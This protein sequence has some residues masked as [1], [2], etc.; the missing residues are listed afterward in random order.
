[1]D[2]GCGHGN[3]LVSCFL[4]GSSFGLG[5]DYGKDSIKYANEIKKKK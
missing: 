1:M 3:F 5:I 2:F 4:N